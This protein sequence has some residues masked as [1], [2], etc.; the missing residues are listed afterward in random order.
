MGSESPAGPTLSNKK[1]GVKMDTQQLYVLKQ[2]TIRIL[3]SQ[4]LK[5]F[6]LCLVFY[7]GIILNFKLL[8]I[9]TEFYL[10]LLAVLILLALLLTQ[11]FMTKKRLS[12]MMYEFYP[13]RIELV[14]KKPKTITFNSITTT[15]LK[16]NLLDT[17]FKTGTIVIKPDFKIE[18]V[19]YPEQVSAYIQKLIRYTRQYR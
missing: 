13:D 18:A 4:F 6:M 10:H 15:T 14:N 7:A 8:N 12:T 9:K 5:T 17:L 19:P 16:K 1:R 11:L 3:F 2:S